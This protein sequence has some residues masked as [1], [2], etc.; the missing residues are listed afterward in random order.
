MDSQSGI[1][2]TEDLYNRLIIFFPFKIFSLFR[3]PLDYV[4][5]LFDSTGKMYQGH[6]HRFSLKTT[7]SH[8][9]LGLHQ[10]GV[11]PCVKC[12]V[13]NIRRAQFMQPTRSQ[14]YDQHYEA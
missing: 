11:L 1:N 9:F 2:I 3:E 12:M 8:E 10:S 6:L 13:C 14:F 5:R 4:S 7:T